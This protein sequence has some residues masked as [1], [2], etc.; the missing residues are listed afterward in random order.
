MYN[1]LQI[2]TALIVK[3]S[4]CAVLWMFLWQLGSVFLCHPRTTF[5]NRSFS[6]TSIPWLSPTLGFPSFP[7]LWIFPQDS[8]PK[9][10]AGSSP[11]ASNFPSS[12][13]AV[14]PRIATHPPEGQ[15]SSSW[16]WGKGLS[17]YSKGSW[18]IRTQGARL[19]CGV[20]ERVMW[21]SLWHRDRRW[22]SPR[23]ADPAWLGFL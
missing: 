8:F 10:N 11:D 7:V 20:R 4:S 19:L 22:C 17:G 2:L 15:A 1:F 3:K 23:E 13:V 16:L 12:L 5:W 14:G 18:G 6:Q 21:R 9:L